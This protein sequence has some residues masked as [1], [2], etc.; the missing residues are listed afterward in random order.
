MNIVGTGTCMSIFFNNCFSQVIS[1]VV[2]VIALYSAST[3]DL[4]T[5]CCFFVCQEIR[6][7]LK[8]M[9]N[10]DLDRLVVGQDAQPESENAALPEVLQ[11]EKNSP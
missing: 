5:V 10:P 7:L 6:L 3:D 2:C 8:K 1:H 9:A 4:A 11:P